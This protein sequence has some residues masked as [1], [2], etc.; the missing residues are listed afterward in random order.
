MTTLT[1]PHVTT[2]GE[3]PATR[4]WLPSFL[5]LAVIWGSS[6]LFIKVGV[7]HLHPVIFTLCRA[8]LGAVT[9]LIVALIGRHRLPTEPR[10]WGHLAFVAV[11]GVVVPFSL[12][13]YAEQAIPSILAGIWNATTPLLVLPMATMVFRVERLTVRRVVGLLF[14]FV[15][16]LVILGV[17]RA[18]TGAA[19]SAQ[20][21][22]LG[23][24]A[25]YGVVTP[26]QRKFLAG[27]P[28]SGVALAAGQVLIAAVILAVMGPLMAGGLPPASDFPLPV[29]G[30]IVGLGVFGTGIGFVLNFRV[31]RLAGA[32][33]SSSVTYLLPVVATVLGVTLLG[34]HLT[35]HQPV[36]VVIVL[37]AVA[38]SQSGSWRLRRSSPAPSGQPSTVEA[39]AETSC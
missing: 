13:G 27:R 4:G 29:I 2:T 15:G 8:V 21:M 12:F 14:G 23:A 32:S 36:G 17:W 31:I 37:A 7:D 3:A 5:A 10:V 24:A 18:P 6:F 38:L 28:E 33:T 16:V 26:Y 25:C 19:L 30:A 9:L 34:E 20:L 1:A 11:I 35:W 39:P 22:A